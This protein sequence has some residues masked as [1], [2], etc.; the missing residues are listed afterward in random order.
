MFI[1]HLLLPFLYALPFFFVFPDKTQYFQFVVGLLCGFLIF[2]LDRF[3]HVFFIQPQTEFSQKIRFHWKNR[4]FTKMMHDLW[5]DRDQQQELITR[6]SVF[7]ISYVALAIYVIT[8]TGSV[9]GIGLILGIGL[10]FCLDFWR[11]R[12]DEE[13]FHKHFLWQL[14]RKLTDKEMT[15]LVISFTLFFLLLSMLVIR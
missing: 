2:V 7:L 11:Y 8:S 9:L 12:R 5:A 6:S 4:Q 1:L 14:K 15:Y 10:H 3:L 13:R